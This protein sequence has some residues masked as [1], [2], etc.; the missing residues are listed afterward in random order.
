MGNLGSEAEEQVRKGGQPF[1][2]HSG[3]LSSHLLT[4]F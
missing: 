2:V 4:L 1:T 3:A